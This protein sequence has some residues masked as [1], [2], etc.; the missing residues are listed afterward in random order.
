[1]S[2]KRAAKPRRVTEHSSRMRAHTLAFA[3]RMVAGDLQFELGRGS[4]SQ[5]ATATPSEVLKWCRNCKRL[6]AKVEKLAEQLTK[7]AMPEWYRLTAPDGA[8]EQK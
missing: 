4:G 1:M 2:A 8:K 5:L 6:A 3:L 7:Q